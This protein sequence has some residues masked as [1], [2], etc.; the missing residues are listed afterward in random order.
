MTKIHSS[1]SKVANDITTI[2]NWINVISYTIANSGTSLKF[3]VSVVIEESLN[4]KL[5]RKKIANEQKVSNKLNMTNS[6]NRP[7]NHTFPTQ[8]TIKNKPLLALLSSEQHI[9]ST[10]AYSCQIT[11][12]Y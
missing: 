11:D 3:Y 4:S 5:S 10:L 2:S 6:K 7:Q 12:S 1:V 9:Y 8:V